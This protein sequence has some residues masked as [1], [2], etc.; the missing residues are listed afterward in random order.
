M[1]NKTMKLHNKDKTFIFKYDPHFSP[2][3]MFSEFKEV[4]HGQK[5]IQPENVMMTND[6]AV[7]HRIISKARLKVFACLKEYQPAN[8]HQLAQSLHRDYTNLKEHGK[9]TQPIVLYEQIVLDFSVNKEVLGRRDIDI[10]L[11]LKY[12]NMKKTTNNQSKTNSVL[13]N[14]QLEQQL[15]KGCCG[16]AMVLTETHPENHNR[17]CYKYTCSQCNSSIFSHEERPKKSIILTTNEYES[18]LS[19]ARM[20]K[21]LTIAEQKQI[22]KDGFQKLKD[23]FLTPEQAERVHL[24][25]VSEDYCPMYVVIRYY[26]QHGDLDL[27]QEAIAH[28]FAH[29]YLNFTNPQH[30]E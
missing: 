5:Y 29:V 15:T 25:E 20:K 3:Q 16:R 24:R 27:L 13:T 17:V 4:I 19:Q 9:E 11:L 21:R 23:K 18:L 28:E 22:V 1:N 10:K 26:F 14:E 6:L 8:I 12:V 30:E 2:Q 7:I